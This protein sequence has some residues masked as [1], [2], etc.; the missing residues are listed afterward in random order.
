MKNIYKLVF[1]LA[2]VLF[3]CITVNY[4]LYEGYTTEE[5]NTDQTKLKEVMKIIQNLFKS[6]VL[7]TK[8][9][10]SNENRQKVEEAVS[11]FVRI[12]QND[13]IKFINQNTSEREQQMKA[14][15]SNF[16]SKVTTTV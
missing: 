15:V 5:R 4:F 7:P 16:L 6:G 14:I 12:I 13:A 11:A 8:I 1:L 9:P 3:S 10:L 2:I